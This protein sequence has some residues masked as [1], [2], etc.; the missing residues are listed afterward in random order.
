MKKDP[1]VIEGAA[2]DTDA[3]ATGDINHV[4]GGFRRGDIAIAD[5]RDGFYSFH[6]RTY[7]VEI[8]SPTKPLLA[9]AAMHEN[10]S[11]SYILQSSRQIRSCQVLIIPAETHFGS[12]RNPDGIDHPFYE[13]RGFSQ[14]SHHR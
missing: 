5:H 1:R 10:G 3:G 11:D 6:D 2:T 13:L 9:S 7:S 14:F 4:F 8:D 12:D